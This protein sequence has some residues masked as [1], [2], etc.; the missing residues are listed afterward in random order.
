MAS[1]TI[2]GVSDFKSYFA[3]D[4]PYGADQSYVMDVDVSNAME[5]AVNFLNQALYQTQSS[6]T[7]GFLDLSAHYLVIALRAASQGIAGQW[8]WMVTSKGTGSLSSG[9]Q[10]PEEIMANPQLAMLTTTYYGCNFVIGVYDQLKGQA[11][12]LPACTNP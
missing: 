7:V 10:I 12:Y 2:P 11:V 6:F 1:W 9:M 3:R 4:F 8:P 5:R